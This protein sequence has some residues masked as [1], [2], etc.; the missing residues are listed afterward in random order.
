[1]SNIKKAV[2][3]IVTIYGF[4]AGFG[5]SMIYRVSQSLPSV[6]M[7]DTYTSLSSKVYDRNNHIIY[8]FY[9]E[10]R[11]P[12]SLDNIPEQVIRATIAVEDRKFYKHHGG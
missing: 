5:V 6:E 7:L 1:M 2:L 12:V 4:F 8:E 3:I 10:K 11:I 9:E